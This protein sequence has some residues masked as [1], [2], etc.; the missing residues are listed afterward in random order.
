GRGTWAVG[1]YHGARISHLRQ[2][3][4]GYFHGQIGNAVPGRENDDGE[5]SPAPGSAGGRRGDRRPCRGAGARGGPA[6]RKA[7]IGNAW[8]P[9]SGKAGGELL[10]HPPRLGR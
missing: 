4:Y 8:D 2:G 9:P 5:P 1:R 6:G 7:C 3:R 10:T